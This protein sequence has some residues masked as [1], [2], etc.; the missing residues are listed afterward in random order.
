V[1]LRIANGPVSWGVDYAGARENPPW[2]LVLDQIARA[3][4]RWTELGPLGY[5]PVDP[6]VL[7]AELDRRRLRLSAGFVFDALHD[8]RERPRVLEA[9]RATASLVAAVGGTHLVLID[10][11]VHER[12]AVAGRPEL[13][14]R[15][16]VDAARALIA[17]LTEAARSASGEHGLRAVLHHHA[18]TFVEYRD[19]IELVLGA[20][21]ARLLGLCLDTGHCAYAGI[22]PVELY[23]SFAPRVDYLHLKDV[24]PRI[25]ARSISARL[26]FDAAVKAGV[27]CPLGSGEVD[28]AALAGALEAN[29]FD[30]WATVE[31]DVDPA[32]A[33]DALG[34]ARRSLAFLGGVGL[35][36]VRESV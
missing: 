36:G 13:A 1:S 12:G 9:V 29:G 17:T 21:D 3:G 20:I 11:P 5:L 16:D 6:A 7:Q 35:G 23:R 28:F 30:G 14:R 8:R 15:L 10:H 32:G 4:Y 27:F 2:D 33:A 24:D 18:G 34:Y 22:D 26:D 19:E 25:R 31:Q